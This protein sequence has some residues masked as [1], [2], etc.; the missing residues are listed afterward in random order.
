M[1]KWVINS[2]QEVNESTVACLVG[3]SFK[4]AVDRTNEFR[5]GWVKGL[6]KASETYTVTELQSFGMIGLYREE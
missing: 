1:L 4:Q 6:P 2:S 3:E 5:L